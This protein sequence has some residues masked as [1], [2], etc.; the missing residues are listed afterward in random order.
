MLLQTR[1]SCRRFLSDILA[2]KECHDWQ[3]GGGGGGGGGCGER[4]VECSLEGAAK[5]DGGTDGEERGEDLVRRVCKE[6]ERDEARKKGR[7]A[8][9]STR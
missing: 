4:L 6:R 5:G 8:A 7:V 2:R 3:G 1:R 9:N